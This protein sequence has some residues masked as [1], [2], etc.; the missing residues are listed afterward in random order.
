MAAKAMPHDIQLLH[1]RRRARQGP[2]F[3]G[4]TVF[5]AKFDTKKVLE[6]SLGIAD[7]RTTEVFKDGKQGARSTAVPQYDTLSGLR[8]KVIR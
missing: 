4:I 1:Q 8:K 2:D 3:M 6:R 7:P 5:V